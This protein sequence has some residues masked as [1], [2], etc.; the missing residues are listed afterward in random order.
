M[1]PTMIAISGQ[2]SV[3]GGSTEIA[4]ILGKEET[5]YR[6]GRAIAQLL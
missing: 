6:L 5:M 1:F 4:E 2:T 3:P